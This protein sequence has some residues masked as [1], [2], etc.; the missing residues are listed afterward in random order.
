MAAISLQ[1]QRLLVV[2]DEFILAADLAG[3]LEELGAEVVGPA[4]SVAEALDLIDAAGRL[5]GAILDVNLG[6]ERIYPVADRLM[7]LA[8]PIVFTT[9]YARGAI[10]DRYASVPCC[11]KPIILRAVL[12]GIGQAEAA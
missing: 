3:A 1:G 4:P 6:G 2:E 11:E 8:V 10:P 5:D 9:G 12:Q 7:A